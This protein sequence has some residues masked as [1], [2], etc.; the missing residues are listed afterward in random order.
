MGP[1]FLDEAG[2]AALL[3]MDDVINVIEIALKDFS[4]G[5]VIQPVRTVVPVVDHDGFL[6]VMPAYSGEALGVKLVS[7]YPNNAVLPTHQ[8]TIMLFDPATGAPLVTM[9]GRLITEVR[10][11]AASAVAT[12]Q[13]AR[14]GPRVLAIL[15]AGVQARSHLEALRLDGTFQD[16]RVWS[17][18]HAAAFAR[19]HDITAADSAESAVRGADIIVV[20][21]S[22]TE[23]VLRGSW[24]SPGTHINAVGACRP[25]WRELDDQTLKHARIFVDSRDAAFVESGDVIAAGTIAGEIGEVIAGTLDGRQSADEITIFKSVGIG[26]EDVATAQ[27]VYRKAITL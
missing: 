21:T 7:V 14:R 15:G 24:L 18:R 27:L 22:A 12:R 10:T 13:L 2:V 5:T 20:A 16:I 17:P 19:E 23:P 25:D 3:R 9:D 26:I 1:I 4:A 11:A 8:A 6:G